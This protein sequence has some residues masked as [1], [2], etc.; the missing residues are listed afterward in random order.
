MAQNTCIEWEVGTNFEGNPEYF[1]FEAVVTD[2]KTKVTH[3]I[4]I[5][6]A[7]GSLLI[8]GSAMGRLAPSIE[9][10]ALYKQFFGSKVFEVVDIDRNCKRTSFPWFDFYFEFYGTTPE[11]WIIKRELFNINDEDHGLT[12]EFVVVSSELSR[13]LPARLRVLY[14]HWYVEEFNVIIF[15]CVSGR[16]RN[17]LFLYDVDSSNCFEIPSHLGKTSVR[18]LVRMA[19]LGNVLNTLLP[20]WKCMES[21]LLFQRF[22]STLR[23]FENP[24]FIHVVLDPTQS[25]I[26][27]HLPRFDLTF[28]ENVERKT[29]VSCNFAGYVVLEN[30]NLQ[31]LHGF[32]QYLLISNGM[33]TRILIPEGN[34]DS[35]SEQFVKITIPSQAS[36]KVRYYWYDFNTI[37]PT[38]IHAPSIE[39]RLYLALIFAANST[40]MIDPLFQRRGYEVACDLLRQCIVYHPLDQREISRMLQICF[41]SSDQYPSLSLL[42]MRCL[43]AQ[44][45]LEFLPFQKMTGLHYTEIPSIVNDH[46]FA[47]RYSRMSSVYYE[48][49]CSAN[50]RVMLSAEE[51]QALSMI[52]KT[53][54]ASCN[55]ISAIRIPFQSQNK[56]GPF[57]C[58][59]K[60]LGSIQP[61]QNKIVTIREQIELWWNTLVIESK[62]TVKLDE[63][64]FGFSQTVNKSGISDEFIR[65]LHASWERFSHSKEKKISQESIAQIIYHIKKEFVSVLQKG[66][67]NLKDAIID[68]MSAHDTVTSTDFMNKDMRNN[69]AIFSVQDFLR[70][71]MLGS[72]VCLNFNSHLDSSSCD[73]IRDACLLWMEGQVLLEKLNRMQSYST[74][75]QQMLLELE[76]RR[77]W[78]REKDPIEWLI[79]EVENKLQ[80]RPKQYDIAW[81]LIQNPG[82]I[83]QLNMGEGKTRVILPMLI[84]Y[85]LQNRDQAMR[86]P[87][88]TVTKGIV[89]LHLLNPLIGEAFDYLHRVLTASSILNIRVLHLPFDR[90]VDLSDENA[91]IMMRRYRDCESNRICLL[92]APEHRLSFYLKHILTQRKDETSSLK[93]IDIHDEADE[94]FRYNYQLIYCL[95]TVQSLPNGTDRWKAAEALLVAL[96]HLIDNRQSMD[97]LAEVGVFESDSQHH[98]GQFPAYRMRDNLSHTVELTWCSLLCESFFNHLS[99]EFQWLE[100]WLTEKKDDLIQFIINKNCDESLLESI[101]IEEDGENDHGFEI[102][103]LRGICAFKSLIHCLSKRNRVEFGVNRGVDALKDL[104]IPFRASE[105][106]AERAEYA[107]PETAIIFTLL[108]YSYDG[109]SEVQLKET[110]QML[111]GIS[112]SDKTKRY[113]E[114]ITL[115]KPDLTVEEY[116]SIDTIDKIDL[117][118]VKQW[119]LM[120]KAFSYNMLTIF[121]WLN[122]KIFPIQ[123]QQFPN[124]LIANSWNLAE[125]SRHG[126]QVN[127]FSGTSDTSLLL[128]RQIQQRNIERE[129]QQ[130][131]DGFMQ[132]LIMKLSPKYILL[133]Y[134]GSEVETANNGVVTASTANASDISTVESS[135][136][137]LWQQALKTCYELRYAAMIDCGAWFSSVSNRDAAKYYISL[138][139]HKHQSLAV[140]HYKA[141][142]FYDQK[143]GSWIIRSMGG[144]EWKLQDSPIREHESFVIYDESHCRGADMKL[145]QFARALF[146][147]GPR[148]CKDKMMQ[149][150]CRLR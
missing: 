81:F 63:S 111:F 22:F 138:S 47:V 33:T 109:L 143:V 48:Q 20:T 144:Q 124:N 5:N 79:F 80:I 147:L 40:C 84:T 97:F 95:G 145:N 38:L 146:T 69:H 19:R 25:V 50:V 129:E 120:I 88:V 128:P 29:I 8:D 150:A 91:S 77:Y 31:G 131:I 12:M 46:D 32:N 123:T 65:N 113:E 134:S 52:E 149:A 82:Y 68:Y 3:L 24:D 45:L 21:N 37:I 130:C 112:K 103:A 125:G 127:G 85:W 13:L 115:S 102:F 76:S 142:V 73:K 30:Q 114:W 54:K 39:S 74:T 117:T 100:A 67:K 7:D 139:S 4:H 11:N 61:L 78:N 10:C 51:L 90:S 99:F 132:E 121:Y 119:Q 110:F 133:D 56:I 57:N 62:R 86:N 23:S 140:G 148:M 75:T 87:P 94:I 118:D 141:V 98:P 41:K 36:A 122:R 16:S 89:R 107:N 9:Q 72:Q 28:Q 55:A 49:F 136:W 105:T 27:Y 26:F 104:A 59:Y 93:F 66:I 64:F 18:S 137:S 58:V 96:K 14:A 53:S 92:V 126:G 1:C 2:E 106:P 17:V 43:F 34:V 70:I 108:A 35:H 6:P 60:L 71:A 42:A 83:T 135:E 116:Q 15:S 101:I 44:Q